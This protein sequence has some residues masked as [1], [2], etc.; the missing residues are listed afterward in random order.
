MKCNAVQWKIN[1]HTQSAREKDI[2][3]LIFYEGVM[4]KRFVA[5]RTVTGSRVHDSFSKPRCDLS[6]SMLH[7]RNL[8][9]CWKSACGFA[10]TLTFD[11]WAWK[12]YQQ[13]PLAWWIFSTSFV[14]LPPLSTETL[15]CVQ[16]CLDLAVTFTFDLESLF[17]LSA[18]LIS[19]MNIC[20]KFRRTS[21]MS[22]KFLF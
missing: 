16:N 17:S 13:L 21:H 8:S 1:I 7:H 2:G 18:V 3:L 4:N 10:V 11:L 12:P 15:H 20:F 5:I 22:L 9:L 6:V 14:E 19:M